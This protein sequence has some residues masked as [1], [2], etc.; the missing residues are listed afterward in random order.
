[1]GG[2][3]LVSFS[4]MDNPDENGVAGNGRRRRA[5]GTQFTANYS[6]GLQLPK[7]NQSNFLFQ[8]QGPDST[9]H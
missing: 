6:I 5:P 2:V 7:I 9:K 4:S 3:A 8:T 1:M